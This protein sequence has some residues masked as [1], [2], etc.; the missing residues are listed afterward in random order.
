MSAGRHRLPARLELTTTV[1]GGTT[2]VRVDG[3]LDS[4]TVDHFERTVD[5]IFARPELAHLVLD[6]GLLTYL[7]SEGIHALMAVH[8]RVR[9]LVTIT[10]VNCP[11]H[12]RQILRVSGL[13]DALL[14]P[15][16]AT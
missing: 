3:E 8:Q 1:D 16:H 5:I 12:A 10:V 6:F 11:E 13:I 15:G 14:E 7:G 2:T 4:D 9:Q